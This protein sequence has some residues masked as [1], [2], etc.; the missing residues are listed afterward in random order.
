MATENHSY[1]LVIIEVGGMLVAAKN[2]ILAVIEAPLTM[3]SKLHPFIFQRHIGYIRN[4][5][6]RKS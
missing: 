1:G 3:K 5:E 4:G 6:T 2:A